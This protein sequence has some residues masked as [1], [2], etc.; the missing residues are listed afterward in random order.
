MAD[1]EAAIKFVKDVSQKIPVQY[2]HDMFMVKSLQAMRSRMDEA[3]QGI[4]EKVKSLLARAT[5]NQDVKDKLSALLSKSLESN[6]E[7]GIKDL[8]AVLQKREN[9]DSQLQALLGV[10]Q[11]S[12]L[13]ANRIEVFR[14]IAGKLLETGTETLSDEEMRE[15]LLKFGP[16]L[17]HVWH[18]A[19]FEC[20]SM[21]ERQMFSRNIYGKEVTFGEE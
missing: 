20:R 9:I 11:Y 18:E 8:Q 12:I 7:D 10:V 17:Q 5:D 21:D 19:F 4:N 15:R 1:K 2:K 14:K 13:L 6:N 16:T 3:N